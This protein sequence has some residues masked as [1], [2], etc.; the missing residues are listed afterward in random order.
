MSSLA[1]TT[2]T[3]GCARRAC[4]ATLATTSSA[5]ACRRLVDVL[6]LRSRCPRRCAKPLPRCCGGVRARRVGPIAPWQRPTPTPTPRPRPPRR[7]P[8][9]RPRPVS[10][11]AAGRRRSAFPNIRRRRARR[12]R[13]PTHSSC[14]R[15][16]RAR[17]RPPRRGCG[18]GGG[19]ARGAA[20]GAPARRSSVHVGGVP[21]RAAAGLGAPPRARLR[22]RALDG[23]GEDALLIAFAHTALRATDDKGQLY[24]STAAPPAAGAAAPPRRRWATALV[25]VPK[26]VGINWQKELDQWQ[27]QLPHEERMPHRALDT[28]EVALLTIGPWAESGGALVITHDLF[29]LVVGKL[30]DGNYGGRGGGGRGGSW[31]QQRPGRRREY[32][33]AAARPGARPAHRRRGSRDQEHRLGSCT[34]RST[35][36]RRRGAC[37]SP[38]RRC[39]TI[40]SSTSTWYHS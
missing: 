8:R 40:C 28:Q 39:R 37:C 17:A 9:A 13:T 18:G 35:A 15:L 25:V 24:S 3:G 26:S 14:G 33:A 38:A 27:E 11:A 2:A 4:D 32:L 5:R 29:R 22:A 36:W 31:A 1:A 30:I 6:R 10:S 19:V 21:R 12:G 23:T 7:P 16:A 34:R 20:Q